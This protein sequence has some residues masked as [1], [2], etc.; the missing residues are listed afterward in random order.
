MAGSERPE[1]ARELH[2]KPL[3]R[4]YSSCGGLTCGEPSAEMANKQTVLH[5][6]SYVAHLAMSKWIQNFLP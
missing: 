6:T 2:E 3:A 4:R 1:V 5:F